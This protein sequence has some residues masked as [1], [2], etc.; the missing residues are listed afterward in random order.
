MLRFENYCH[1]FFKWLFRFKILFCVMSE[2]D[3]GVGFQERNAKFFAEKWWQ[4]PKMFY[5]YHR[6]TGSFDTGTYRWCIFGHKTPEN[7]YFT[8]ITAVNV[9]WNDPNGGFQDHCNF[10]AEKSG[11]NLDEIVHAITHMYIPMYV[12]THIC[13]YLGTYLN[14]SNRLTNL[15][16]NY[17]RNET[18]EL[19]RNY[20]SSVV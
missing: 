4:S 11:H 6:P 10:F 12:H 15:L 17:D 13:M 5:M 2:V 8:P 1:L 7:C 9:D 14:C 16:I 18:N 19:V 20:F 3:L